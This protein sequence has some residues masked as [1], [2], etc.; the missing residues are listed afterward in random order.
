MELAA[1]LLL[2]TFNEDRAAARSTSS[3][4]TA[5]RVMVDGSLTASDAHVIDAG[6]SDHRPV[7]VTLLLGEHEVMCAT[8]G[9]R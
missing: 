7:V 4:S 5:Y 8:T 3:S 9:A 2:V 6:G 1:L